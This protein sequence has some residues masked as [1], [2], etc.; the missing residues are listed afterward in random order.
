MR[1]REWADLLRSGIDCLTPAALEEG[2]E[3]VLEEPGRLS[4]GGGFGLSV[5]FAPDVGRQIRRYMAEA[6]N[7]VAGQRRSTSVCSTWS[8]SD[9]LRVGLVVCAAPR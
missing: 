1:I 6:Q 4:P 2:F 9:R 8:G 3:P 7:D 5:A